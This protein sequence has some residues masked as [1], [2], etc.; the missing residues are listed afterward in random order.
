MLKLKPRMGK[1]FDDENERHSAELPLAI[2]FTRF[3]ECEV[4][5]KTKSH[6]FFTRKEDMEYKP[7]AILEEVKEMNHA[8]KVQDYFAKKESEAFSIRDEIARAFGVL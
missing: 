5:M 2:L 8:E 6:V 4:K 7:V 3:P 1:Y